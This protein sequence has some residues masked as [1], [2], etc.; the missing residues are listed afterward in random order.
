MAASRSTPRVRFIA[1]LLVLTIAGVAFA[2]RTG[3]PRASAEAARLVAFALVAV[4][5]LWR[6]WASVHIAGFKDTVLVRSGPYSAC[7]HP[8]YL[9]SLLAMLGIGIATRSIAL[10][11]LLIAGSAVA[12]ARAIREEDQFLRRAHGTAFE[13]YCSEVPALWPD[14]SRYA[15]PE[16]LEVRPRVLWK[17]FL[18]AGS[19]IGACLLVVLADVLQVRGITPALLNLP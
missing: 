17:A 15:V 5:A 14:F 3:L 8:L 10:A 1:A 11:A 9:G 2:E 6:L 13:R 7:R 18:D 4:A 19:I 12:H 16:V